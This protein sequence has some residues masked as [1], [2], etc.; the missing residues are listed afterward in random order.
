MGA[1]GYFLGGKEP[2]HERDHSLPSP[3]YLFMAWCL[4]KHSENCTFTF[5][6]LMAVNFAALY[7]VNCIDKIKTS[8]A[9]DVSDIKYKNLSLHLNN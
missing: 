5:I 4:I 7:F 6:L 3:P 8:T 9:R 1:G 2:G